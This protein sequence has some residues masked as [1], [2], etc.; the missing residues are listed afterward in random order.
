MFL[1][2]HT[3]HLI[4]IGTIVVAASGMTW[5]VR[6]HPEMSKGVRVALAAAVACAVVAYW[7]LSFRAGELT[8]WDFIP[9]QLCDF[10]LFL[11]IFALLTRWRPAVELLYFWAGSGTLLAILMPDV[12]GGF[13]RWR[14][15]TFFVL[16]GAV[17]VSAAVLVFGLGDRPAPGAVLRAVIATNAY[18]CVV[19]T[20]DV[21]T[22]MNFL[23]LRAKPVEPSLLDWFGPWPFYI[24]GAELVMFGMFLLLRELSRLLPLCSGQHTSQ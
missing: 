24:V 12:A 10:A 22:G 20:V 17:V 2:F 11:A 13:L 21:A 16:H 8:R 15:V 5:I 3:A 1:R 7:V 19:A 6:R 4:A 9:L 14:T 18:A 23:Y